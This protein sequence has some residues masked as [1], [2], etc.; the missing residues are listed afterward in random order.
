MGTACHAGPPA[1]GL[2]PVRMLGALLIA[3]VLLIP[4]GAASAGQESSDGLIAETHKRETNAG[5]D[6]NAYESPNWGYTIEW[7]EAGWKAMEVTSE[8]G[9]DTLH[10][11]TSRSSLYFFGEAGH[12]GDP[13]A[14]LEDWGDALSSEKDVDD[15]KPL[16]D[17]DGDPVAG[18]RR[19][20]AWAAFTLNYANEEGDEFGYV[21]YLECRSLVE[22]E[23]TLTILHVT[24]EDD[25]QAESEAVAEVLDSIELAADDDARDRRSDGHASG[26][27]ERVRRDVMNLVDIS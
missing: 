4:A 18:A 10:L 9:L 2:Q 1:G 24:G 8:D 11:R 16:E 13:A 14:C 19:D 6:G 23:S 27:E 5:L 21:V 26:K 25:Y 7:D 20:R 15:W 17:E 22:D 12:R 3:A